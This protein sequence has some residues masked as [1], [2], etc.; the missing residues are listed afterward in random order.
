MRVA[1]FGQRSF[2]GGVLRSLVERHEIALVVSPPNDE[3]GREDRTRATAS[4][5]DL[6]WRASGTVTPDEFPDDVD[7]I[8]CAHSHDFVGRR[9]RARSRFGAVGYHPSLLPLHRGRDAVRWT[10][11]M[12]DRVAGG[13]VYWLSDN[14]DGGDVAAQEWCFVRPDDDASS[15]WRRELF[16]IGVRLL[17]RVVDDVSAGV[18]VRV[19][20]D[21]ELA[22]WE[23]SWSRPPLRRPELLCL[24]EPGKRGPEFVRTR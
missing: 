13:S 1:L 21:E 2:G 4:L 6:P 5:L 17:N 24:P 7:L 9:T 19:P 14:V 8:V 3:D 20:Q 22:T 12:R 23:P 10:I 11:H 16:P 18:L 15:L